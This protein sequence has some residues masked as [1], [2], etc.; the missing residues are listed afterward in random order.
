M[1]SKTPPALGL[2]AKDIV[3]G[4]AGVIVSQHEYLH[5]CTRYALEP[6]KL[7]KDGKPIESAVFDVHRIQVMKAKNIGIKTVPE[8]SPAQLGN[9]AKDIVTGFEG[10][11]SAKH[12]YIGGDVMVTLES[13]SLNKDKD[14]IKSK[15]FPA[16][17]IEVIKATPI[18]MAS[19]VTPE[20]NLARGGP[21]RDAV[22]SRRA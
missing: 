13:T 6:R 10:I 8:A 15:L 21:Q 9:K 7:D 18:P 16:K 2:E 1:V 14:E 5:G 11:V 19:H 3:T 12:L 22:R 20:S 4:F 17:R